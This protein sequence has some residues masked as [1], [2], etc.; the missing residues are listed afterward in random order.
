MELV[1][2]LAHIWLII[3]LF[4][5]WVYAS[6]CPEDLSRKRGVPEVYGGPIPAS[7]VAPGAG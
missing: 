7:V 3:N 2:Y 4:Y 1:L 5:F 6:M